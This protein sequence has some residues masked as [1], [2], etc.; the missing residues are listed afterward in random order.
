MSILLAI[1]HWVAALIV[2]AEALNKLERA[3]L[4]GRNYTLRGRVAVWLSVVAWAVLAAGSAG[5]LVAPLMAFTWPITPDTLALW[6]VAAWVVGA[7]T[8]AHRSRADDNN[9]TPGVG[10]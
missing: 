6:G 8:R 9:P 7:R 5:I 1:V 3:D 2:L 10:R 4:R